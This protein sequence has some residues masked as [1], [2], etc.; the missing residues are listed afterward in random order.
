MIFSDGDGDAAQRR[1]LQ[2][3]PE[4]KTH[5]SCSLR[6]RN[7]PMFKVKFPLQDNPTEILL[8]ICRGDNVALV[9]RQEKTIKLFLC[10]MRKIHVL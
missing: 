8:R 3:W 2:V 5:V 4:S 1:H 9:R 7:E 6:L 10:N